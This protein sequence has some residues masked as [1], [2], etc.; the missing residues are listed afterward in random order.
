M[1]KNKPTKKRCQISNKIVDNKDVIICDYAVDYVKKLGYKVI[2]PKTISSIKV[3]TMIFIILGSLLLIPSVSAQ[4]TQEGFLSMDFQT[5]P[6]LAINS[7]YILFGLALFFFII[8]M[9]IVS[10]MFTIIAG[11]ILLINTEIANIIGLGVI[12]SGIIIMFI[13]DEDISIK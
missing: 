3:M 9:I 7:I 6:D 8:K 2:P 1:T 12:L 10:S 13:N 5:N 11:F 4:T